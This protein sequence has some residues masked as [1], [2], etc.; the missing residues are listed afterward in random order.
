MIA[1]KCLFNAN[2]QLE[3]P[4]HHSTQENQLFDWCNEFW[5]AAFYVF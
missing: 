4:A 5:C 1:E 2:Y 3:S